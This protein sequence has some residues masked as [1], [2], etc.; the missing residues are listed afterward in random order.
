MSEAPFRLNEN[1]AEKTELP[2]GFDKLQVPEKA[3][4]VDGL[5]KEITDLVSALEMQ[6]DAIPNDLLSSRA[7]GTITEFPK[8]YKFESLAP[9]KLQKQKIM[10]M[11]T[12]HQGS[13]RNP[14]IA[15]TTQDGTV[16][17]W[18]ASGQKFEMMRVGK[19]N[20]MSINANKSGNV[21][22]TG[23]LNCMVELYS[24][25]EELRFLCGDDQPAFQFPAQTVGSIPPGQPHQFRMALGETNGAVSGLEFLT[26]N[27]LAA[28]SQNGKLLV[29]DIQS[30]VPIIS[31][32]Y[33]AP[34]NCI[35]SINEFVFCTA[36]QDGCLK[37]W[38]TR[39]KH[40]DE[41]VKV[42]D[43]WLP[44][45]GIKLMPE[46]NSVLLSELNRL[47][48]LDLRAG[49]TVEK[50]ETTSGIMNAFDVS[51]SGR[52]AICGLDSGILY[53]L[54]LL[55]NKRIAQLDHRKD[56]VSGI[57]IIDDKVFC[58]SWDGVLSGYKPQQM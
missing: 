38:D 18:D 34:I 3:Q 45:S 9:M 42:S 29:Y 39:Q 23:G 50:Y 17:C 31:H 21:L 5:Q 58:S 46:S 44:I 22:A 13:G 15:T 43:T 55:A 8:T 47:H 27:T 14:C 53:S 56:Q 48:L 19:G 32:L 25:G 20:L 24:V 40:L 16:I 12:F 30:R 51:P 36:A 10:T 2:D 26:D 1:N 37:V 7:A 4:Y 11:C 33:P 49:V 54:D 28:V 57:S 52:V 41:A 35:S 6:R